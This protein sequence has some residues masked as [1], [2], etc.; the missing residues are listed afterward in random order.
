MI[1]LLVLAK[2][3]TGDL[4]NVAY[5]IFFHESRKIFYLFAL[6]VSVLL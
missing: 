5:C 1:Y 3:I 4:K 2:N 6:I